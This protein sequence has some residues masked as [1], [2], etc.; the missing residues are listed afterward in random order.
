MA[1]ERRNNKDL[2][3][4]ITGFQTAMQEAMNQGFDAID[5]RLTESHRERREAEAKF[6]AALD[7]HYGRKPTSHHS[8]LDGQV[9]ENTKAIS[10]GRTVLWVLSIVGGVI[11]GGL[12]FFRDWILHFLGAG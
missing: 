6:W 2:I 11:W 1:E 12:L 10:K 7:D 9:S 8:L 4:A 5:K 3:L